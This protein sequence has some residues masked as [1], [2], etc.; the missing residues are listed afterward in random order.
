[1]PWDYSRPSS[2]Q[3]P[4]TRQTS[5]PLPEEIGGGGGRRADG[6]SSVGGGGK[7]AGGNSSVGGG[8]KRV[9]GGS[10]VGS[11]GERT[12]GDLSVGWDGG[13]KRAGGGASVRE[14]NSVRAT[15]VKRAS[16]V[17]SPSAASSVLLADDG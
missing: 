4:V 12:G 11:D 2:A 9:C 10:S 6:I 17:P 5:V 16:K 15:A 3:K 14:K 1:M 13:V 7:R 8:G